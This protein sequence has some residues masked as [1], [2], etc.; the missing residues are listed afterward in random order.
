MANGVI[1]ELPRFAAD[2]ALE[3][4]EKLD[5]YGPFLTA[6]R[7]AGADGGPLFPETAGGG[8]GLERCLLALLNGPAIRKIDD[9]TFFGKNPDSAPLYLF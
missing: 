1:P 6:A 2:G 7:L 8:L 9:L 4:M 3:N 5:G